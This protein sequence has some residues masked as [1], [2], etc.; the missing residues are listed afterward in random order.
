M[1][2][3]AAAAG[4]WLPGPEDHGPGGAAEV[5]GSSD[6]AAASL[7]RVSRRALVTKREALDREAQGRTL[8]RPPLAGKQTH[9]SGSNRFG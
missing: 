1:Q 2:D 4:F 9:E 6:R 8:S 7:H 5:S 3:D